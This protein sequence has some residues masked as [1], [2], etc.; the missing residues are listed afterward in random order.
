M[1][2]YPSSDPATVPGFGSQTLTVGELGKILELSSVIESYGHAGH[3]YYAHTD[4]IVEQ[5]QG[6][7]PLFLF[8]PLELWLNEFHQEWENLAPEARLSLPQSIYMVIRAYQALRS[9]N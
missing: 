8:T 2:T 9:S 7:E 6:I 1:D 3:I 4:L 5:M